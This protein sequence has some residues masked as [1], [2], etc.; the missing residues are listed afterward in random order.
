M[1][2]RGKR[3]VVAAAALVFAAG[4]SFAGDL[5]GTDLELMIDHTGPFGEPVGGTYTYGT[6]EEFFDSFGFSW[7]ANSPNGTA[8][9][10]NSILIDFANFAYGDF[11]GETATVDMTGIDIDPQPGSFAVLN[12]AGTNI[13]FNYTSGSGALGAQYL[14]DDVLSTGVN[15]VVLAWDNVIPAPGALALLG[16][17]GVAARRRRRA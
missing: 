10:D 1:Q 12:S 14:V 9:F 6:F 4:A 2:M 7:S 16:I 8:G 11:G 13:G 3:V 5:T 17:A 15:T